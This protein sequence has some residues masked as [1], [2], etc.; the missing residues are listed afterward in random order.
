MVPQCEVNIHLLPHHRASRQNTNLK[1]P[2]LEF[3]V[4]EQDGVLDSIF[5]GELH[6]GETL[7]VACEL[8]AQNGDAVDL[9]ARLEEGLQLLAGDGVVDLGQ[10]RRED[11]HQYDHYVAESH[12]MM[13]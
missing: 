5:V 10:K 8:V 6:I 7:G 12:T 13:K 3:C 11:T 2:A 4:V 1:Q 9:A